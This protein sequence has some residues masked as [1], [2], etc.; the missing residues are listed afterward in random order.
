MPRPT[1]IT[2]EEWVEMLRHRY[3]WLIDDI[4]IRRRGYRYRSDAPRLAV[5]ERDL[6][7]L[8]WFRSELRKYQNGRV[9]MY[10]RLFHG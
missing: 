6:R 3:R 10:R 9:M 1:L 8:L 5:T 2:D 7:T 4:V